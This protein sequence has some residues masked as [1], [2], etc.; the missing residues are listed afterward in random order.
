MAL[1]ENNRSTCFAFK[2]VAKIVHFLCLASVQFIFFENNE[3][4]FFSISFVPD[5]QGD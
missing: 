4:F 1:S 5:F 2:A 3:H